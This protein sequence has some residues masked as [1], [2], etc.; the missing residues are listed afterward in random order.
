VLIAY[1]RESEVIPLR[2]LRLIRGYSLYHPD[3]ENDPENRGYSLY[4]AHNYKENSP[5]LGLKELQL[6]S[7]HGEN[8]STFLCS[9]VSGRHF[10]PSC[11]FC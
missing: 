3:P 1:I 8:G 11:S 7:L 2:N 4:V 10:C 6:N 9:I 5:G